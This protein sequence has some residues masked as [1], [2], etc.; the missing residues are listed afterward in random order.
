MNCM[1]FCRN[2]GNNIGVEKFRNNETFD[3]NKKV[4]NKYFF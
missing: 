2:M 1:T 3:T 4:L